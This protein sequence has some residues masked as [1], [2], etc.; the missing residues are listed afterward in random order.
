M[1]TLVNEE[2]V[3]VPPVTSTLVAFSVV[4]WP[5]AMVPV[6][7]SDTATLVRLVS[8]GSRT[9]AW[10]VTDRSPCCTARLVK[11]GRAIWLPEPSA[12]NWTYWLV[13]VTV[14]SAG[15]SNWPPCLAS[16]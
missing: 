1:L 6:P 10:L 12:M 13:A 11:S 4:H 15:K 2:S 16:R 5:T 3:V 9:V 8:L 14:A 7:S